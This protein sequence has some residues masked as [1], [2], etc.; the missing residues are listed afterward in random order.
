MVKENLNNLISQ[1]E[2]AEIRGVSLAAIADL[3]KRGRLNAVV[4]GGR[5]YLR[6]TDVLRFR[7]KK[8]GRPPRPKGAA[9]S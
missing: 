8:G 5:N 1:K 7:S 2:A 4:I 3:I 6:K 9:K